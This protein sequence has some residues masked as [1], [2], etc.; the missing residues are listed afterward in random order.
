MGAL[1]S[2]VLAGAACSRGIALAITPA[3]T[4]AKRA[5]FRPTRRLGPVRETRGGHG[6]SPPGVS[7]TARSERHVVFCL[8]PFL[9]FSPRSFTPARARRSRSA[10]PG[11]VECRRCTTT[12]D[13][14]ESQDETGRGEAGVM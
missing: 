2:T 5:R 11:A 12:R 1:S 10:L 13:D 8:F 4:D 9:S 6:E 7:D 14:R 3:L